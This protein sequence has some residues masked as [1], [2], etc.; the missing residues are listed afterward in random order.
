V[1]CIVAGMCDLQ[2]ARSKMCGSWL[3]ARGSAVPHTVVGG[4]LAALLW[5]ARPPKQAGPGEV[6]CN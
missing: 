6:G 3:V 5:P 4:R 2:H 1:I